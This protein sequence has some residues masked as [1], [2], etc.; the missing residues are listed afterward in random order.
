MAVGFDGAQGGIILTASHNPRQW[1]ALKLLDAS[2]EFLSAE[3]GNRLLQLADAEAFDFVEVDQL[4]SYTQKEYTEAHLEAVLSHPLVDVEAIYRSGFSVVLDGINSVGGIIMPRLLSALGV[5]CHAIHCEPTGDFAHNPEPLPAHLVDLSAA[6]VAHQ[7]QLGISVDPDVDRLALVCEDGSMFGEEYTLVACADYVL[8]QTAATLRAQG[9]P[10]PVMHT[11]S[12]L[13]STRAL[14]DVTEQHGG[15][16]TAAA[17]GEV[18]VVAEMKRQ[19]CLI[20]GEGNGGVIL[21]SLHPGR[22]AL[23]GVA[24]FLSHLAHLNASS[25]QPFT[26]SALRNS[27]PSYFISKN[28]VD[29]QEGMDTEALFEKVKQAYAAERISTVDGLR[30]D[31]E[32]QKAW[33]CLRK[34]NT[35]AILRIYAEAPQRDEAETLSAAVIALLK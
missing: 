24:L 33:V 19:G 1:N 30:I 29:L 14:R 3:A 15:I 18:N 2:G 20:G 35:E 13:S 12:N 11:T 32:A 25:A 17:V 10:V 21:P 27:Y 31:F 9:L 16:Y 6:V 7:A 26:V 28:R 22:D 23:I 34:S 5:T 8:G 4:G